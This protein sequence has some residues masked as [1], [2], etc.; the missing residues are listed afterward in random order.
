MFGE[1][2]SLGEVEASGHLGR[3][4]STACQWMAHHQPMRQEMCGHSARS[5]SRATH[6]TESARR[7]RER[8]QRQTVDGRRAC[9][10]VRPGRRSHHVDQAWDPSH[11]PKRSSC[12]AGCSRQQWLEAGAQS[13]TSPWWQISLLEPIDSDEYVRIG[14]EIHRYWLTLDGEIRI[15]SRVSRK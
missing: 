12:M 4:S 14:D 3:S 7:R 6:T 8:C 10:G 1:T 13:S 11:I 5:R 9:R 15:H 2:T